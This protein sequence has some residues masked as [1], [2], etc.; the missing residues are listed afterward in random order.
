[1]TVA[2]T[3]FVFQLAAALISL[4]FLYWAYASLSEAA[5]AGLFL[6][7]PL[8]V[9]LIILGLR[10]TSAQPAAGNP[11]IFG[12]LLDGCPTNAFTNTSNGTAI[13]VLPTK[14][15]ANGYYL[16]IHAGGP[17][18]RD[19]VRWTV[20]AQAAD[21]GVWLP[22]GASVCRGQGAFATYF[23]NLPYP[24]P[25]SPVSAENWIVRVVVDR[26]PKWQ[27]L[28]TEV[29]TYVVAGIGWGAY[30]AAGMAGRQ[31]V[32]VR[33]LSSLFSCN[34]GLQAIAAT[35]YSV[36]GDWRAGAEAWMNCAAVVGIAAVLLFKERLVI[37]G[38][39]LFGGITL[40]VQVLCT[41]HVPNRVCETCSDGGNSTCKVS[42]V[43]ASPCWPTLIG[44]LC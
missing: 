25:E 2:A 13:V 29:G 18:T 42:T 36:A 37:S 20:E 8:A 38:L 11:V 15:I 27:W 28:L 24:T 12:L 40:L 6:P 44:G 35:G 41:P 16:Q 39:I 17:A 23:P 26:R 43:T 34:S 7:Q 4:Y 10:N 31:L 1:V 14:A 9:R 3:K 30:S 22:V 33:L 32:A 21:G 19:P 5:A